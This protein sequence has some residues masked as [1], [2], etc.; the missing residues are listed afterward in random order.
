MVA[1]IMLGF[2]FFFFGSRLDLTWAPAVELRSLNNW[3]TRKAPMLGLIIV[4]LWGMNAK[5]NNNKKVLKC[6]SIEC[7][8]TKFWL[9]FIVCSNSSISIAKIRWK[10]KR[11]K[12]PVLFLSNSRILQTPLVLNLCGWCLY[13]LESFPSSVPIIGSLLPFKS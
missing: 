8:Q 4:C 5:E 10:R 11:K 13:C 9:L 6:L 3:I 12:F 1:R 2:V 7:L